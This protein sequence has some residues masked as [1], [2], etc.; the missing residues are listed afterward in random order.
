ML[1]ATR[2]FFTYMKRISDGN[3]ERVQACP[4]PKEQADLDRAIRIKA[5]W[6]HVVVVEEGVCPECGDEAI[7]KIQS[8]EQCGTCCFGMH[9]TFH[10]QPRSPYVPA[11][12]HKLDR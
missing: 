2:L 12:H 10:L 6:Q 11:D 5:G 8:G 4:Q 7:E 1:K 9:V 3:W